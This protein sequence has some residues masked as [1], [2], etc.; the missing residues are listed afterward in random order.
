M[1]IAYKHGRIRSNVR[2]IK[3]DRKMLARKIVE[4]SAVLLKNEENILPLPAGKT[5]A[6][7]GRAKIGIL[8]SGNG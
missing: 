3:M 1:H 2:R 6:F 8:C 5:V 7:F 4:E